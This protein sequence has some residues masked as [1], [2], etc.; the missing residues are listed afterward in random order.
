[1][2]RTYE[3]KLAYSRG[4]QAGSKG[5]WSENRPPHPPDE[6]VREV[7]EAM[8]NLRDIIDNQLAMLN[9]ENWEAVFGPAIQRCDDAMIAITKWLR[10]KEEADAE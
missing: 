2:P 10:S 6:R 7:I 4:Y 1:M 8:Q 3:E 9:D 5:Y